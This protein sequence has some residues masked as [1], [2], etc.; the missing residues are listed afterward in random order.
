MIRPWV[1]ERIKIREGAGNPLPIS[2][3]IPSVKNLSCG[4]NAGNRKSRAREKSQADNFDSGKGSLGKRLNV[5]HG[6]SEGLGSKKSKVVPIIRESSEISAVLALLFLFTSQYPSII[7]SSCMLQP[8]II[9]VY[10]EA[11]FSLESVEE[12]VA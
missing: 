12:L 6:S 5:K 11:P 8:V 10:S 7:L 9:Q 2:N 1:L 3:M 4:S